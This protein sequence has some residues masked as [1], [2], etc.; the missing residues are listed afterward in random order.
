MGNIRILMIGD[1]VGKPGRHAVATLLPALI[2]EKQIDFVIANG[3]NSAGG[4]GITPSVAEAFFSQGVHVITGGNHTL[5]RKEILPLMEEDERMI[6]PANY[7]MDF[8]GRG[9][10]IRN[11]ASFPIAVLNLEGTVFLKEWDNPFLVADKIVAR[12]AQTTPI[13]FVDFHAEATS[14][15]V[16]MGYHLNGRVT[17]VVG[18][19]THVQTSDARILDQG[20]AYITDVGMTGPVESVIGVTT[21]SALARFV[22]QK[23]QKFVTAKGDSKMEGCIV[24]ADSKTGR[25]I[26]IE[27]F[28]VKISG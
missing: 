19:H 1:I 5:K 13:I 6:R 9:A 14:E 8:P 24:V 10:V 11:D 28:R 20:T 21:Q 16:A 18:T 15:K 27:A 22:T 25:A 3:E 7:P 4:V 12:L 26:S 23:R 2:I 17:A